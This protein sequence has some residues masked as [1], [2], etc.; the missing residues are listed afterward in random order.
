[1]STALFAREQS[2]TISVPILRMIR[3]LA[4]DALVRFRKSAIETN[5]V[6]HVNARV[7]AIG[8]SLVNMVSMIMRK[9]KR[10]R[11]QPGKNQSVIRGAGLV[12]ASTVLLVPYIFI[13]AS[14]N[15]KECAGCGFN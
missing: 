4:T 2:K 6:K 11:M 14:N 13:S 8:F 3:G 9:R 5:P 1:M 10:M 12:S 7:T 15:Q